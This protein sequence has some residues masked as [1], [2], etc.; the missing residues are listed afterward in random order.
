M[1]FSEWFIVYTLNARGSS[2][3]T[4]VF[5]LTVFLTIGGRKTTGRW[6]LISVLN[7]IGFWLIPSYMFCIT[8]LFSLLSVMLSI[9]LYLPVLQYIGIGVFTNNPLTKLYSSESYMLDF[10][11]DITSIYR[12]ITPKVGVL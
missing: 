2:L 1:V 12:R 5:L 3:Q 11:N 4:A 10:Y 6:L 8:I 7:A 9:L